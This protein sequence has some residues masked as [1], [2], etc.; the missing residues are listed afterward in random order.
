MVGPNKPRE[1]MRKV[2][3]L[4]LCFV[5][6]SYQLGFAQ[7]AGE[8][9]I[10]GY[11]KQAQGS[12]VPDRF[13][14][15]HMRYFSYDSLTDQFRLL[16][17]KGDLKDIAGAQ[18]EESTRTLLSYFLIGV[19]LPDESFWVNLRPD[20]EDQIID[21]ALAKTD[22][23]KILLETDLQLKKDTAKFTSPQTPE[24]K[25]YWDKLFQKAEELYG[26]DN[27]TIPTLLTRP[28]IVPDEALIRET[29]DS[30]YIYKGTLKVLLEQD[31]LKD[32]SVSKINDTRLKTLNEYS[33]QLI[34]ELV[35]PKLTKEVNTSKRYAGLRQVYYS[36]ILA[37]WFKSRF[38]NKP[39]LYPSMINKSELNGLTSTVPWSKT[40]YFNAYQ[41]S[42]KEGEYNIKDQG[43]FSGPVRTYFSGGI[44]M[45][46]VMPK[47]APISVPTTIRP[48]TIGP[49]AAASPVTFG[50]FTST[51]K[52][53]FNLPEI[54]SSSPLMSGF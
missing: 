53:N 45:N 8:L 16:L 15:L 30:A 2:L 20:S 34:R 31:Y 50:T 40:T 39:G 22:V 27:F 35:I 43:S 47:L 1:K 49:V 24:G 38:Y 44:E 33:S 18:L 25:E 41:K 32:S 10:A 37:R 29:A 12:F 19:N 23:G 5:F 11:L 4:F 14:P 36:L 13:R 28:W 17:D 54:L 52:R 42:F 46:M 48:T 51:E 6:M 7:G 26:N 21:D 9:N 3:S